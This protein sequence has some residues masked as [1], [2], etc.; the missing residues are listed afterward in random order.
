MGLP[1]KINTTTTNSSPEKHHTS[2]VADDSNKIKLVKQVIE[3]T[4][5][6]NIIS[7]SLFYSDKS[8]LV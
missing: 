1:S 5:Q 6:P 4:S 7:D 2:T 8:I 3:E